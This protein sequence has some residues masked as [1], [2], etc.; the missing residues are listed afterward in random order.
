[1]TIRQLSMKV[2]EQLGYDNDQDQEYLATLIDVASNGAN[3]GF[4]GFTYYEDTTR[5]FDE[6]RSLILDL[7]KQTYADLGYKSL[8]EMINSFNCIME[9]KIDLMDIYAV[10][11]GHDHELDDET[12]TIL[13]NALALYALEECA[14]F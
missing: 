3:S 6:N 12:K 9:D 2:M 10:L 11:G 8:D 5:F 13:K 4:S 7:L 14:H 1:M